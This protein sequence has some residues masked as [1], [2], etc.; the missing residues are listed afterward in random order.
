MNGFIFDNWPTEYKYL[1]EEVITNKFEDIIYLCMKGGM[2]YKE[3]NNILEKTFLRVMDRRFPEMTF[4]E[5]AKL[6]GIV[7]RKYRSLRHKH[8]PCATKT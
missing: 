3:I 5:K 4:P 8:K 6:S 1:K 7:L 2:T